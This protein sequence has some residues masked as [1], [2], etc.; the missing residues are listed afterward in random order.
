M[1]KFSFILLLTLIFSLLLSVNIFAETLIDVT[2]KDGQTIKLDSDKD[3]KIHLTTYP[4]IRRLGIES[5]VPIKDLTREVLDKVV[6]DVVK[7]EE[8]VSVYIEKEL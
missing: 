7:I 3:Y 8:M 5:F 1:K 2:G 4:I 6:P